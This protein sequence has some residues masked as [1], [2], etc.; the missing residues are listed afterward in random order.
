M[1]FRIRHISRSAVEFEHSENV[2]AQVGDNDLLFEANYFCVCDCSHRLWGKIIF[3]S[4]LI[5][6]LTGLSEHGMT[7][8][9]F[10]ISG[11][12]DDRKRRLILNLFGVFSSLF[13]LIVL[14]LLSNSEYQRPPE[15]D[16]EK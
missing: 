3:L 13:G 7:S 15:Q 8:S 9:F 5:A 16:V 14:Y 1:D 12:D 4:A 10:P 2:H 6:I 11:K